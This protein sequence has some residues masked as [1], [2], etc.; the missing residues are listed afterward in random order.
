MISIQRLGLSRF[1]F[2]KFI[3]AN[4][5][6]RHN[7]GNAEQQPLEECGNMLIMVLA[8]YQRTKDVAYLNQHY[9]ILKQW[10]DFLIDEA[11]IPANQISTDDFAGSLVNQTNLAIKGII[12]IQAMAQIAEVTGNDADGQNFTNIAKDYVT[13]WMDLAIAETSANFTRP[14]TILSYGNN[15]TYGLLY[16]LYADRLLGLDLVPQE[17]YDMQSEFYPEV[18][19][20]YGV[21]LD[22]R[23][24]LTKST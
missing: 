22:T 10:N 5:A 24:S 1:Q 11:L 20:T 16:N 18:F 6:F 9:D 8:Y 23:H 4:T 7:D 14:H 15:D 12:G 2:S 13:R 19:E 3:L 17:V 21:P